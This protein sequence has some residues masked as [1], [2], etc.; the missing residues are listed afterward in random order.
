MS[1]TL[2]VKAPALSTDAVVRLLVCWTTM[3]VAIYLAVSFATYVPIETA[4]PGPFA[5]LGGALGRIASKGVVEAFGVGAF[6]L[7][8]FLVFVAW[9]IRTQTRLRDPLLKLLGLAVSMLALGVVFDVI[10]PDRTLMRADIPV[11][12]ILGS[13]LAHKLVAHL[14]SWWS[15]VFTGLAVGGALLLAT[16]TF[17]L[18][19][20]ANW[21]SRIAP[22]K[23]EAAKVR[24]RKR[25]AR[26]LEESTK[27][28]PGVETDDGDASEDTGAES[29]EIAA[30]RPKKARRAKAEPEFTVAEDD[31]GDDTFDDDA[32]K[33]PERKSR[34]RTTAAAEDS[35][36]EDEDETGDEDSA[37]DMKKPAGG[38]KAKDPVPPKLARIRDSAPAKPDGKGVTVINLARD[39]KLKGKE[40][41]ELPP[42][43]LLADP[44]HSKDRES[45][46][47]LQEKARG[48]I[49][50]L[51]DFSVDAEVEEIERGP[52]ITRFD[53]NLARGTKISRVTGLAEDLGMSLGVGRVRIAQ[54]KG[55]AALGV[56]IPNKFR[57]TVFLKEIALAAATA[58]PN[59]KI[60]IPLFLGKDSSGNPIIEDLATTPHLLIAGRTGAGKSVFVNSLVLSILLTRY[61]EEVRLVMIDPKRVELEQYQDL[62]HLLT[63]VESDPKKATMILEWAVMQM[64]ERYEVLSAA[65][66]RSIA[67]YN[68]LGKEQ[69]EQSL[70]RFYSKEEI[71]KLPATMPYVVIIVD[72]LADLM[73]TAGKEV[74]QAIARLAQKARAVGIHVVLATQRPSTDVITGL[75]KSNMPARIA[76]QTRTGIDSRTILDRHGA[77][78]LLDKGDMLYLAA[79]SDDPRRC[80]GPFV[81]DDEVVR[82]VKYLREK[83]AP[84]YEQSLIQVGT[85]TAEKSDAA[86]Q[87]ELF[88]KAVE[89]VL[90]SKQ[91]STSWIQRQLSVG[92][93]RAGRLIDLMAEAGYISGPRGSK[94]REI[95][96]TIEQWNDLKNGNTE[97][98]VS[99]A[100]R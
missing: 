47:V 41:Y 13:F 35:L 76:F 91:A 28:L 33:E 50:V 6:G 42:L 37:D 39:P 80:Q 10:L 93:A 29:P 81:S 1:R 16:D 12:G 94:P 20:L 83:A 44:E 66:M 78:K 19:G 77:E 79:T 90:E 58:A 34:A 75:I 89:I 48:L 2:D 3:I 99:E 88:E 68:K 18:E 71:E 64:E 30:K 53:L 36:V 72:E 17:L 24:E 98:S 70:S 100:S 86:D 11:G 56:E 73:M 22:P 63:R 15:V 25:Q 31:A 27:A 26:A 43:S 57:E 5:N 4:N 82:V 65:G 45:D 67:G 59:K 23:T 49:Q 54:V 92:Y 52:V 84:Q 95:L 60:A 62:P 21:I 87:D 96:I 61:P 8:F 14:G 97:E 9:R 69:R 51:K 46:E 40:K 38:E 85:Q 74:E 32:T 7:P 55:K